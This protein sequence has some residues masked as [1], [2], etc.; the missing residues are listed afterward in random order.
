MFRLTGLY[1][2][3]SVPSVGRGQLGRFK[4]V[5]T[6]LFPM[7]IAL[8]PLVFIVLEVRKQSTRVSTR[9][10]FGHFRRVETV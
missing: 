9:E 7:W 1:G 10:R 4:T 8:V 2:A 6:V 3:V 5:T